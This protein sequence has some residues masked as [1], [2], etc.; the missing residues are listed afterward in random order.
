MVELTKINAGIYRQIAGKD[1][2]ISPEEWDRAGI[3]ENGMS[4]FHKEVDRDHDGLVSSSELSAKILSAWQDQV[5]GQNNL[6][7]RPAFIDQYLASFTAETTFVAEYEYNNFFFTVPADANS[8]VFS[9]QIKIAEYV[10]LSSP[11]TNIVFMAANTEIAAEL[12]SRIGERNPEYLASGR[13]K[14][15]IGSNITEYWA[16]DLGESSASGYVVGWPAIGFEDRN[17]GVPFSE[18]QMEGFNMEQVVQMPAVLQGGNV[19]TTTI[20]GRK[21]VIIGSNDARHTKKIYHDK[22]GYDISTEEIK[23]IYKTTFGADDV[24]ILGEE[25]QQPK[26]IFHIDQAVFFPSDGIAVM[27]TPTYEPSG[28]YEESTVNALQMYKQQLEDYGFSVIEIPTTYE[29]IFDYQA[30]TNSVVIQ[31]NIFEVNEGSNII[32]PSFGDTELE[33]RIAAVL[34]EHGMTVLF[35]PDYAFKWQGNIHCVT[36]P[37][38]SEKKPQKAKV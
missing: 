22:Y 24:I 8:N 1:N 27:M 18:T 34:E 19:T 3:E 23:L 38:P 14:I 15:E 37:L 26:Y 6:H 21:V 25:K 7:S 36:G 20:G 32:M 2:K 12:S 10:L 13:I 28:Y 17:R 31:R 35:V 4:L 11:D 30:Y 33:N 16:Q 29:H 5:F 9:E